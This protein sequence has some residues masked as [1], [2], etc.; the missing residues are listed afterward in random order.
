MKRGLE[1]MCNAP[2]SPRSFD[3]YATPQ[4]S[5]KRSLREGTVYIFGTRGC[6]KSSL[7]N[8]LVG[9]PIFPL[10][11]EPSTVVET[12]YSNRNGFALELIE[13][14]K[15]ASGDTVSVSRAHEFDSVENLRA[16]I[17]ARDNRN[18]HRVVI[19]FRF[20][21]IPD[22]YFALGV[23]DMPFNPSPSGD[24]ELIQPD[25][26]I[27]WVSPYNHPILNGES[28]DF[29]DAVYEINPRMFNSMIYVISKLDQCPLN[30]TAAY[31]A[32]VMV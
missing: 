1:G 8:A 21:R 14:C 15:H 6:G 16:F 12:V 29:S 10:N 32:S 31:R 23:V 3:V 30:R 5:P 4:P 9:S 25:G 27:V 20:S 13:E 24:I 22:T 7:I 18:I 19:H 2:D 26:L 28:C 11:L 17:G